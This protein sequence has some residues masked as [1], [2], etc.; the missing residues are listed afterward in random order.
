MSL[1]MAGICLPTFVLG[2]LLVL[3]FALWLKWFNPVR[4]VRSRRP[5]FARVDAGYLSTPRTS[6]G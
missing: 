4:L 2:P 1:A 5:R 6:R 3:V